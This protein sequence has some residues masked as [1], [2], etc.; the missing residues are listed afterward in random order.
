MA[1]YFFPTGGEPQMQAASQAGIGGGMFGNLGSRLSDFASSPMGM[2]LLLGLIQGAQ[3][4]NQDEYVDV[5]F[6]VKRRV[7]P[8][9]GKVFRS[10]LGGAAAGGMR[11]KL[12]EQAAQKEEDTLAKRWAMEQGGRESMQKAGLTAQAELQKAGFAHAEGLEK[13]RR[14]ADAERD[15][16]DRLWREQQ[17]GRR[18][19]H[20]AMLKNKF[21]NPE[22]AEQ[23]RRENARWLAEQ[24]RLENKD[25]AYADLQRE[26]HAKTSEELDLLRAQAEAARALAGKREGETLQEGGGQGGGANWM[27]PNVM[28]QRAAGGQPEVQI[29]YQ[30]GATPPPAATAA[31]APGTGQVQPTV[32]TTAAEKLQNMMQHGYTP[33][34]PEADKRAVE[35][36]IGRKLTWAE[37]MAI[38]QKER[39]P[40]PAN[41]NTPWANIHLVP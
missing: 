4:A 34:L 39:Q 2:N 14:A 41:P 7:K 40:A 26:L 36:M 22:L 23:L 20:E 29:P 11:G 35:N 10:A 30:R 32:A 9:F 37:Y 3:Q 12:A 16:V 13:G 19:T 15:R 38:K 27:L 33:P 25:I 1:N 18:Q 21:A 6:G 17:E 31:G 8:T 28:G 24:A 5:G